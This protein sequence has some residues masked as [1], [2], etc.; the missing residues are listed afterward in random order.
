M[1]LVLHEKSGRKHLHVALERYNH[2]TGKVIPFSHNYA[3]H[4]S[5]GQKLSRHFGL[6]E[7]PER[8]PSRTI[9]KD[10]LTRLWEETQDATSFLQ[11]AKQEGYMVSKGYDRK[12]FLVVDSTGRS[13]NLVRHLDGINTKAVKERFKGIA[14]MEEREAVAVVRSQT[15]MAKNKQGLNRQ[16]DRQAFLDILQQKRNLQKTLKPRMH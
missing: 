2:E 3:R 13:F 10:T 9:M 6:Q 16:D 1:A 14:L 8:N 5:A 7:M 11:R 4:L 15:T 12:P